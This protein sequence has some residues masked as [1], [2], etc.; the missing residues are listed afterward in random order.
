VVVG[1][2]TEETQLVV[3]G[4]GPGGYVAAFKAADLGIETTLIE[5][6]PSLGG[7]CLREGCIPSKALLHVA[8]LIDHAAEAS[9]FGLSFGQ[10]QIDL[11]RLRSW[12]QSVVDKLSG[13][14]STLAGKRNV[15]VVHGNAAF[16][17]VA[18]GS[19]P[20]RLPESIIPSD[21]CLDSTGALAL[22][23]IP[24]TLAVIGGG[25]IGLELGQLYAAL[26]AKVT[27]IEM[28]PQLLPGPDADLVRPL[29]ARLKKQFE[30]IHTS[31]EL[32]SA[33]KTGKGVELTFA[34]GGAEQ[35]Q[36]F[37]RVLVSVGRKPNAQ[38]LGLE[39]TKVKRNQR[40]FIEVDAQRRTAD[41]RIFAIGDVAGEP[42]LAHKASR[43]GIVAAQVIAGQPGVFD[44]QAI[45]AIVYT[46]P[47]VAW[48]GL[49][50]TQAK[51]QGLEIKVGKFP[52]GASGRAV[53]MGC[54]EG[55][56]KIIADARTRRVL[57]VG[58]VG[59][60]AGDLIAEATL[61]IEMGAEVQDLALT[62]HPHPTTS[63]TIMEAAESV[64]GKAIHSV[65]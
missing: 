19:Q 8:H 13:G 22:P 56:T 3:I 28:L 34:K 53:T 65:R 12:K 17:I 57:G 21:C 30:A 61:A 2:L 10:P 50:E 52:W 60:N 1:E 51:E 39:N 26:G 9:A 45:P 33:R 16:A 38:N 27:V 63:E 62:I 20:A 40:G 55:V 18:T 49:I 37:Q 47:E 6:A 5:T 59:E 42:M 48:C 25:Y 15:R 46:S 24:E 54:P 31:A 14:V 36:T 41:K 35:R 32:R 23:E 4:G 43:E 58:I 11:E 44:P 7:V 64:F 29:A